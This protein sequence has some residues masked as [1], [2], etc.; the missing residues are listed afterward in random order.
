MKEMKIHLRK[1][2]EKN[3]I[4]EVSFKKNT[5]KHLKKENLIY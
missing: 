2:R 5:S 4:F 1:K 3:K